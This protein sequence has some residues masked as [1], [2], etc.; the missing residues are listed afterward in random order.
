MTDSVIRTDQGWELLIPFVELHA[1][2]HKLTAAIRK[3]NDV[4]VLLARCAFKF[5]HAPF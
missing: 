3:T 4:T 2:T 5:L 1:S